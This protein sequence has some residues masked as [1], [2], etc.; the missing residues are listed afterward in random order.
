MEYSFKEETVWF[1]V[2]TEKARIW[3]VSLGQEKIHFQIILKFFA[4]SN[5]YRYFFNMGTK[6]VE[7]WLCPCNPRDPTSDPHRPSCLP[8]TKPALVQFVCGLRSFIP[9]F[10]PG[11]GCS[12]EGIQSLWAHSFMTCSP[13]LLCCSALC[14]VWAEFQAFLACYEM[15]LF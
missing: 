15:S 14:P 4:I 7:V 5:C 6:Q 13:W 3:K 10:A 8:K 2:F 11:P 1:V 12:A 9:F